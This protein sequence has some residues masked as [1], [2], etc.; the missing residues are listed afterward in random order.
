VSPDGHRHGGLVG[1]FFQRSWEAEF[2]QDLR[3]DAVD[4]RA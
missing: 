2:G 1:E 4:E 3:L